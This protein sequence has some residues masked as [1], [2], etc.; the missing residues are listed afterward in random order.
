MYHHILSVYKLTIFPNDN[1][2]FANFKELI[3]YRNWLA[4]GRGWDFDI[5]W[6]KFDFEYSLSLI[7]RI[8]S[9]M[10]NFPLN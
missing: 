10:P 3:D 7:E 9:L 4:H 8:I 5:N 1:I 2:A 6:K